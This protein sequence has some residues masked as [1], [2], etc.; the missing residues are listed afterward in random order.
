MT[1]VFKLF[2]LKLKIGG[3]RKMIRK[4]IPVECIIPKLCLCAKYFLGN[5]NIV[6]L[7]FEFLYMTSEVIEGLLEMVGNV[8]EK[9]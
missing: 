2:D 3:D 9:S 8:D 7:R 4:I 5:K 1:D 6:D